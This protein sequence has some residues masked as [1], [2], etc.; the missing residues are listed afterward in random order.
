MNRLDP[1][2]KS[3]CFKGF[4]EID[5]GKRSAVIEA[6]L[7]K[8]DAPRSLVHIEHVWQ[9]G[10]DNRSMT[11]ISV[12]ELSPRQARESCLRKFGE[13]NS[14]FVLHCGTHVLLMLRNLQAPLGARKQCSP[15]I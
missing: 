1:A 14:K 8:M 15:M 13:D 9:G 4:T 5:A 12:I 6:L 10:P 7:T 2:N 11:P 3:L